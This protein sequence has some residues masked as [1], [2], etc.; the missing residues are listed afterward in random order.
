[1]NNLRLD[2]KEVRAIKWLFKEIDL[3]ELDEKGDVS[4]Y[5]S[6]SVF[7]NGH[8]HFYIDGDYLKRLQGIKNKLNK[9]KRSKRNV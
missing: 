4:L 6:S 1:M 9:A 5:E 3:L 7:K 8:I 2:D